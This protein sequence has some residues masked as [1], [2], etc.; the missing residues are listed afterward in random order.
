[1]A[2]YNINNIRSINEAGAHKKFIKKAGEVYNKNV[3]KARLYG[4]L[5]AEYTAKGDFQ[6]A[7]KMKK[8]KND[9]YEKSY[10]GNTPEQRIVTKNHIIHSEPYVK[11]SNGYKGLTPS[12]KQDMRDRVRLIK[13]FLKDRG[14]DYIGDKKPNRYLD[15]AKGSLKEAAQYILDVLDEQEYYDEYDNSND[16]YYYE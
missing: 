5:E 15:A 13:K 9:Y 11:K 3:S 12:Q 2:I 4:D 1:M 14:T 10:L 8:R 16:Y 7:D 6:R